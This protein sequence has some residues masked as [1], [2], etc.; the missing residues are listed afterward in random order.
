[1]GELLTAFQLV[2][3]G[4]PTEIVRLEKIDL[5]TLVKGRKPVRIQVKASRFKRAYVDTRARGGNRPYSTYHFSVCSGGHPKQPL[6]KEQCDV[7]ALVAIDLERII[8][9]R[10]KELEGRI[11]KRMGPSR[12]YDGCTETTWGNCLRYKPQLTV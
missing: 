11:T 3:M 7:V 9:L 2:K 4:Y 12:F 8:F 10:T 5:L 6:T 1:M